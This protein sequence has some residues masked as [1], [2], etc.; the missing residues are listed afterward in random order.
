LMATVAILA[1]V[2]APVVAQQGQQMQHG[3]GM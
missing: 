1:A 2:G 3:Q